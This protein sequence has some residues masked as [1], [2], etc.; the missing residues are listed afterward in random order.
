MKY[1]DYS[2]KQ[3]KWAK[4]RLQFKCDYCDNQ[5][6]E[7]RSKA[8]KK[9]RHFCS[10]ACWGKY[11]KEIMPPNEQPSWR[12][13]ITPYES[14]RRW[15]K[16]NPER[17]AHLKARRYARKR[18]AEGSHSLEEW[19]ELCKKYNWQCAI[20]R[21]KKK[22]TKD[23]IKPLSLNGT[24][25]I[26]NIQPL[27]RNCNSRKWKKFQHIRKPRINQKTMT[28]K[29]KIQFLVKLIELQLTGGDPEKIDRMNE[30]YHRIKYNITI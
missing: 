24:D 14:H 7:S 2:R 8:K 20:C 11:R 19:Q 23:H 16:K 13:G 12:G 3:P 6:W 26:S 30:E 10:M 28:K 4:T 18:N 25:Y 9:K 5:F 21:Q 1:G 27:C 29:E 22:L 15:V 17:M